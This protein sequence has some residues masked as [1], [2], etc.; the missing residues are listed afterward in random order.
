MIC[1]LKDGIG[2]DSF[3]FG[4]EI[5]NGVAVRAAVGTTT[6]IGEVV[7][8]VLRFVTRSAPDGS[9]MFRFV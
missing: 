1:L 6:G 9:L 3:E 4:L 7:A 5:A 2:F 8:I